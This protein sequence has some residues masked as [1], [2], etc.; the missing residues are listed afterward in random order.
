MLGHC[1]ALLSQTHLHL[2]AIYIRQLKNTTIFFGKWE[3]TGRKI[4]DWTQGEHEKLTQDETG[5]PRAVSADAAFCTTMLHEFIHL[6][7]L[8]CLTL[9][10]VRYIF[11]GSLWMMK[12]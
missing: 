2:R 3:K 4:G 5:N 7:V 1:G 6:F 11:F 8:F 12:I 10:G 9:Y